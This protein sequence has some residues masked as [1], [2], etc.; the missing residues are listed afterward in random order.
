VKTPVITAAPKRYI[1]F[2]KSS[3]LNIS[4]EISPESLFE[5]TLIDAPMSLGVKR[6]NIFEIMV[7]RIPKISWYLYL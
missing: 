6:A 1:I 5:T 7:I 4:C 2:R 3:V